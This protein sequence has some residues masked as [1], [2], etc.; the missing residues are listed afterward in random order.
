[1]RR[2]F[3]ARAII[4]QPQ[5]RAEPT[6]VLAATSDISPSRLCSADMQ[7]RLE[8]CG[9]LAHRGKTRRVICSVAKYQLFR[10]PPRLID[11]THA[12]P[13]LEPCWDFNN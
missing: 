7:H 6:A 11:R 4:C 9:D 3:S 2:D 10:A 1:M 5:P 13:P 12:G 8:T